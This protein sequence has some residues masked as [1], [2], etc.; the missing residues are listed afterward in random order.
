[1]WGENVKKNA[2]SA[3]AKVSLEEYYIVSETKL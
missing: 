1:M 2:E 3:K